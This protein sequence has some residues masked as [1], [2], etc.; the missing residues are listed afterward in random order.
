MIV[1]PA[2]DVFQNR[3]VRLNK[4]E[5]DKI[6]F[7]PNLPLQQA[8]IFY[9]YG[10]KWLHLVDLIGSKTGEISV[11]GL[12]TEIKSN[13]KLKIEFGGGIR[14]IKNAEELFA[15]GV[16]KII[17]GSLSVQKKTEFEK[18]IDEFGPE[19]IIVAA[20]VMN[21]NLVIKGWTEQTSISVFD[22]IGY[23]KSF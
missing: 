19:K 14:N 15:C 8:E 7:Y 9:N 13:I 17:I 18:I 16:D 21:E 4:G 10:F 23:C 12:I 2:I 20:D 3:I 22:H 5:F 11:K 1:I 6:N